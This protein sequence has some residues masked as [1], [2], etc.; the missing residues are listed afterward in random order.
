M[1]DTQK[2]PA[3]LDAP[4]VI[5]RVYNKE[6]DS[7][8]VNGFLVG[9]VGRKV[10][11]TFSTTTFPNDTIIFDFTEKN[12]LNVYVLLYQLT[13]IYTDGTRSTMLGCERTA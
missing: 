12:E 9:K 11:Q 4:Q 13:M 8:T 10:G 2:V 7:L 5:R 1:S 6:D 3:E